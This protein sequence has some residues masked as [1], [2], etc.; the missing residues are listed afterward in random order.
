[1][2]M[3]AT[4]K[5]KRLQ[6]GDSDILRLQGKISKVD[7]MISRVGGYDGA[8]ENGHPQNKVLT[9]LQQRK[10]NLVCLLKKENQ[11]LTESVKNSL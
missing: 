6:Q 8:W 7:E 2:K 10:E 4:R 3:S 1:M 5:L 11:Q 9:E